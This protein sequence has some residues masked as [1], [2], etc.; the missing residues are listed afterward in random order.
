MK[1]V[2]GSGTNFRA[3]GLP[4]NSAVGGRQGSWVPWQLL[5]SH[6]WLGLCSVLGDRIF[7]QR[8]VINQAHVVTHWVCVLIAWEGCWGVAV[9]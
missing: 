4:S 7:A 5:W 2:R 3:L 1:D 8:N 9:V 6:D